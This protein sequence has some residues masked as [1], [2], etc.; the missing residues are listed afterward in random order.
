MT[1][2]RTNALESLNL[3]LTRR[4]PMILQTEASECG[5][6]SLTMVAAYF[7]YQTDLADLRRRYGLS[8]KGATLKDLVRIAD[9]L[10]FATRPIRLELDEL[11]KLRLPC[12]LHWDLNH[13]VVLISVAR[14]GM[15][16]HDP[17]VGVRRMRRGAGTLPD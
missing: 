7:G 10:G 3:G 2:G 6:A 8:L 15:V 11:C 12:I 14:S 4:I 9:Q 5:L 1:P 13:F 16:I 17:A